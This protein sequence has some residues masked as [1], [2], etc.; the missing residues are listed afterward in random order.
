M[1]GTPL[2][3]LQAEA[4]LERHSI[5]DLIEDLLAHLIQ[6]MPTFPLPFLINVLRKKAGGSG[7]DLTTVSVP[8]LLCHTS[9]KKNILT[10]HLTERHAAKKQ[11]SRLALTLRS[12]STL[13]VA[14]AN[15][16]PAGG[17]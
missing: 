5:D 7:G 16:I 12:R 1:E 14:T 13:G 2:T 11:H 8:P 3:E 6:H 15:C 4:Y 17:A 9:F 10:F